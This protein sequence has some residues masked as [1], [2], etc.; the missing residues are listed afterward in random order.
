MGLGLK[1]FDPTYSKGKL[2]GA[3]QASG[4]DYLI[5]PFVALGNDVFEAIGNELIKALQPD[6]DYSDR[7]V[8]TR[9]PTT[10]RRIIYG[11]ARVG[12][13][14]IFAE[15]VAKDDRLLLL[16]I[17]LAGHSCEEIGDI[18]INGEPVT[19]SKFDGLVSIY[20][21]PQTG[22]NTELNRQN[23]QSGRTNYRYDEIAYVYMT[24]NY[25]QEVFSGVPAITATV[26]GKN[27]IYDPRTGQ[28]GYT[29]NAA[30]CMLDF[31]RVERGI[32]DSLI[33]MQSWSDAADIADQQVAAASGGTEP[34]FTL[35]GTLVRTGSKLQSL[36][37]MAVNSGIYLAREAGIYSAVPSVY[38]APEADAVITESDIIGDISIST[39]NG[40]Q[41]KI[42]TVVG[43]YIDAATNYEQVEYPSIQTPT[44]ETE[45]R[46]VLQ[47]SIDYQLVNS[48]TQ[49]RRLSKIA[50]EQSRR[51]ISVS[52]N[53]RYRLLQYTVGTRV[54]MDYSAF[55]WS[56]KI[57]R[58]VARKIS[59]QDGVNLT[60]REDD[61]AIY[62]WEEG[63]ALAT[64]VP[65]FLE[66]PNPNVVQ[67]PTSFT[68]VESLYQANT[69]AA[70]KAR[71]SFAWT[72]DD[73][74][75]QVFELEGSYEGGQYRSLSSY[76]RGNEFKFDD[77]QIGSWVF[78]V[79]GVNSIGASSPWTTLSKPIFGKQAPPSDVTGFKGTVRP[80]SIELSWDEIPDL[81][82]KLYEVRVGLSW[83]TGT[84][85]QKL[86]AISW[87]WETRPTG[88]ER[89]F[90]KAIDTSGNYSAQASEAQITILAPKSPAPINAEVVD[91]NTALRWVNATTSFSI[92]KYEVRRG[93]T[94]ESSS[95]VYEVT[96][97]G[98]QVQETQK[99]T[100]TYWIRGID[101]NG[102]AGEPASVTANVDQPPDFIL[103]SDA[104]LNFND[105]VVVNMADT[106]KA[107]ITIDNDTITIDNTAVT[108][109]SDTQSVFVGPANITE[110][111]A[112]HFEKLPSYVLPTTIDNDTVT[113]DSTATIDNDYQSIQQ[114]Q[115]NNGYNAYLQPTPATASL[116][117]VKDYLGE[118][119]LSRIQLTPDVEILSGAPID[120]YKIAYSADGI[121]YTETTGLE[122]IG[123]NFRYVRVRVEVASQSE[124]DLLR[125]NALRVRL[126]VKLK[127]DAGRVN[128]TQTG[129]TP[130]TFNVPFV[131]IQS[132]T[133]SANGT[134]FRNAIYDF[135]D[136]PNPSGF[137]VYL[138]DENGNELSSGEV[139]WN[140]RGV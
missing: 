56:E 97:T 31:L 85:L 23:L 32:D 118:L 46:E 116:E 87:N 89:V 129:G 128:V 104:N 47:Q 58:V 140:A 9:G 120:T 135:V 82:S 11:E 114:L 5:N 48:G 26:K 38:T 61:P 98:K 60:L 1:D 113:I 102:N 53:G 13:Q 71:A 133:V 76:I 25:D 121:S 136:T 63:D 52:F 111:W 83:D 41:D 72:N 18:F 96:G 3:L 57:F 33:N 138:F 36:T 124:L 107:G 40:K 7:K 131:D 62:S 54:K 84:V 106:I 8:N 21:Q 28:S 109:D 90:I 16:T 68:M 122:A 73:A 101:V 115:I 17:A 14:V 35:N 134:T 69:Q 70:I 27:T 92:A 132:L 100:Y 37:K 130:V 91:N 44:W 55:G 34:R 80:F 78:R 51:G 19:D 49:C 74:S 137:D 42:N 112:E 94:F 43:T 139:S 66:L 81:D 20:K 119:A 67:K 95:L 6:I 50:L 12:G 123:V 103:Q 108:I 39:G 127:T 15:S 79:R 75:A 93:D 77:L 45:D 117:I 29:D 10:P 105:A 88:T 2:G 24:F 64:V 99:G 30:L 126:D 22:I 59:P 125:I 110:T 4:L 65:P 86:T